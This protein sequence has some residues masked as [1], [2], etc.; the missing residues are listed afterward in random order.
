VAAE[1]FKIGTVFTE[2][3]DD[4]ALALSRFVTGNP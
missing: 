3:D 2:L 1:Q 4:V